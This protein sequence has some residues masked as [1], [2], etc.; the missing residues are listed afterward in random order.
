MIQTDFGVVELGGQ[1]VTEDEC[2]EE[3]GRTLSITT[4]KK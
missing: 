1:C 2:G 3:P 4:S